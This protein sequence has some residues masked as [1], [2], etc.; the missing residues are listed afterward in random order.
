[1]ASNHIDVGLIRLEESVKFFAQIDTL[2]LANNDAIFCDKYAIDVAPVI[3]GAFCK[4]N[5][6]TRRD[7]CELHGLYLLILGANPGVLYKNAP[8]QKTHRHEKQRKSE[9]REKIQTRSHKK[10]TPSPRRVKGYEGDGMLLDF[11][12]GA[13]D[14]AGLTEDT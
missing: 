10:I 11:F 12:V 5:D 1:M 4:G 9:R 8:M 3:D 2:E 14:L 7:D 13:D 6:L